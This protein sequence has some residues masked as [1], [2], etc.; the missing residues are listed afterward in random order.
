MPHDAFRRRTAANVAETHEKNLTARSTHLLIDPAAP[1]APDPNPRAYPLPPAAL[2]AA[3]AHECACRIP[4]REAARASRLS[5]AASPAI[6]RTGAG[7]SRGTHRDRC[8]A[9]RPRT[10]RDARPPGHPGA[11][12]P[13][14]G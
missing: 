7:S 1:R 3:T 13:E 14:R 6:R 5:R 10:P 12:A 11:R 2:R 8:A 4:A 9:M